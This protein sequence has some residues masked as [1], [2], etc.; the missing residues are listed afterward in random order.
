MVY[1]VQK[2]YINIEG[3]SPFSHINEVSPKYQFQAFKMPFVLRSKEKR[4]V[5]P[6]TFSDL[7]LSQD[8]IVDEIIVSPTS[9]FRTVYDSKKN[10]CYKV[11]LLR[12]ITR[13][14]RDLPAE[15]L[16]IS[17]RAT[18]LLSDY[19]FDGF[20]FLSEDCHFAE[21]PVFNYIQRKMPEGDFFPWFYAIASQEFDSKFE[22]DT[23]SQIIRSWMFF[24]SKGIFLE[25]HTQNIL[26]DEN[27]NLRYRDL[28][29]VR[30]DE[31][32]VLRPSYA[33]GPNS[34]EIMLAT[35]FDRAVCNQNLDHLFRY[36]QKL[37]DRE[38]NTL[39][40]LIKAEIDKYDLPF[41]D[42]SMDY[43]K[44]STERVPEKKELVWWRNFQ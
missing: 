19:Q 17:E 43:P 41:P 14:T 13:V 8:E 12:K 18:E 4:P 35:K 9:S 31:D 38:K 23:A 10:I 32:S 6:D 39:K 2:E 15:E 29:D 11:P 27:S 42:Y 28:S 37:K 21:D 20:N 36:S 16:K 1:D 26:V 24:A 25:Y 40:E 33:N 30:A 5:H 22:V 44:N 3:Y 34:M 7:G